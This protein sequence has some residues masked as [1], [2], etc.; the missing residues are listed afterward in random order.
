MVIKLQQRAIGVDAADTKNAE[1]E[2]E[3][4]DKI[5]GRFANDTAVAISISA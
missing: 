4:R 2:A 1:V 5:E 3:L